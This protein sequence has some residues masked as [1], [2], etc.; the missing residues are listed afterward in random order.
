M[1]TWAGEKRKR[2][3]LEHCEAITPQVLKNLP[4]AREEE[5]KEVSGKKEW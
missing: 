1:L 4:G 2:E 5:T 3:G